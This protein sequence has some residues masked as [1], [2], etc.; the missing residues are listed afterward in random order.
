LHAIKKTEMGSL[1]LGHN[2][3]QTQILAT[4]VCNIFVSFKCCGLV[5]VGSKI[6]MFGFTHKK[7]AMLGLK[8]WESRHAYRFTHKHTQA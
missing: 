1:L 2:V 6:S 7:M 4:R 3:E 8:Q 5:L